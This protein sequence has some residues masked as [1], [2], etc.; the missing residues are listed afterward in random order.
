M[1]DLIP[2]AIAEGA[3]LSGALALVG[4][5]GPVRLYMPAAWTPAA[6]TVQ[7]SHDGGDTWLDLYDASGTEYSIAAAASRAIVLPPAD[8]PDGRL[9]RLR[10]GTAASAVNQAAARTIYALVRRI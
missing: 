10:S 4:G 3:S 7:E 9:I 2:L 8:F 6:L 1:H 5:T